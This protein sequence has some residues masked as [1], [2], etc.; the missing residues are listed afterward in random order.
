[1][2]GLAIAVA[3]RARNHAGTVPRLQAV[4]PAAADTL[5]HETIPSKDHEQAALL[6]RPLPNAQCG[7]AQGR[8]TL[9]NTRAIPPENANPPDK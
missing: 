6:R 7:T 8:D 3:C 9:A 2:N 1:M 4:H 5:P